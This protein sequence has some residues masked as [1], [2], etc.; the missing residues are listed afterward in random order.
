MP[1]IYEKQSDSLII[2]SLFAQRRYYTYAKIW[3]CAYFVVCVLLVSV[4]AILKAYYKCDFVTGL[5]IGLSIAV[6]FAASFINEFVDRNKKNAAEIQ[7]YIDVSLFAE[8]GSSCNNWQSPL[9]KNRI[10]EI[11]SSFPKNGFCENDKWYEDY[12]TKSFNNQVVLCQKENIRWDKDLR[13][14]YKYFCLALLIVAI[15][16]I[17]CIGLINNPSLLE[18]LGFISWILPFVKYCSSFYKRMEQDEKKLKE[19][20]D[21]ADSLVELDFDNNPNAINDLIKLQNEIF[22]HRKKAVL[23]PNKFFGFFHHSFQKREE[24]IAENFRGEN[25]DTRD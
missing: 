17:F 23:I 16:T 6:M 22:E 13:G 3:T 25:H 9:T 21:F 7:Q 15:V 11:V 1:S 14:W 8:K 12:S 18:V 4:F 20:N 5:S 10:M 19:M 2:Q 24:N